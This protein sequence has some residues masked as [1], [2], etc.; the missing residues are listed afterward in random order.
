MPVTPLGCSS[1]RPRSPS[2]SHAAIPSAAPSNRSVTP[3]TWISPATTR[4]PNRSHGSGE[5][6]SVRPVSSR[7]E[8]GTGEVIRV[9]RPQVVEALADPD[10]LDGDPE[11]GGDRQRDAALRGAVRSEER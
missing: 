8:E 4:K 7:R 9:E 10:Q 3:S 2:I 11:L 5:P 1:L 6:P